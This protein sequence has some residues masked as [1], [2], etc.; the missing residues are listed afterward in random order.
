MWAPPRAGAVAARGAGR[1]GSAMAGSSVPVWLGGCLGPVSLYYDEA[2]V[3][4][5]PSTMHWVAAWGGAVRMIA[6]L[7]RIQCAEVHAEQPL[8]SVPD[9]EGG[10]GARDTKT[11]ENRRGERRYSPSSPLSPC[12]CGRNASPGGLPLQLRVP[13]PLPTYPSS[14][15]ARTDSA[16]GGGGTAWRRPTRPT[17]TVCDHQRQVDPRPNFK[18]CTQAA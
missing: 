18:V 5:R 3:P 12:G 6:R 8:K 4:S 2:S 1:V 11:G 15:V 7:L 10:N 9:T 17:A 14:R 13:A 16:A